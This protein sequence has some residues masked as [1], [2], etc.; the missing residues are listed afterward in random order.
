MLWTWHP[1]FRPWGSFCVS[2]YFFR[3]T[4]TLLYLRNR[5]VIMANLSSLVAAKCFRTT[6]NG[7]TNDDKL[8]FNVITGLPYRS[9][10]GFLMI[11]WLNSPLRC[12]LLR[13]IHLLLSQRGI[14]EWVCYVNI[15]S[16]R[17][18]GW[19]VLA[20]SAAQGARDAKSVWNKNTGSIPKEFP[21][22]S[23]ASSKGHR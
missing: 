8:L 10:G 3:R 20:I 6:K 5:I 14:D 4:T 15:T 2:T 11:L 18:L 21:F 9:C 1:I 12:P 16:I 17:F 23:I 22:P 19:R 7:V 13:R